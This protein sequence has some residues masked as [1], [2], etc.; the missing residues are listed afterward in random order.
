M[1]ASFILTK[2]KREYRQDTPNPK[3]SVS[4]ETYRRLQEIAA[5]AN[6]SISSIAN[7]AIAHALAELQWVEE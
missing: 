7:Q 2:A 3:I 6:M 1:T 5:E 4:R